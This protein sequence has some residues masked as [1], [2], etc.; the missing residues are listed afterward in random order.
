[1]PFLNWADEQFYRFAHCGLLRAFFLPGF[2][3]STVRESL[4]RSPLSF[5]DFRKVSSN[6]MSA[7]A[8]PSLIAS[9]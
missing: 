9:A 5:K 2:F 3:R 1:M 8:I 6:L 4:V 7:L